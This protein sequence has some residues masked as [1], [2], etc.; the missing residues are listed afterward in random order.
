MAVAQR[1]HTT[2]RP[3]LHHPE[4]NKQQDPPPPRTGSSRDKR[5]PGAPESIIRGCPADSARA[6]PGRPRRGGP[7]DLGIADQTWVLVATPVRTPTMHESLVPQVEHVGCSGAPDAAHRAKPK[8]ETHAQQEWHQ[9]GHHV[10]RGARQQSTQSFQAGVHVVTSLLG[11]RH[12]KKQDNK[13]SALCSCAQPQVD[14]MGCPLC[15]FCTVPPSYP[16]WGSR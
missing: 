15:I 6:G 7:G 9:H 14:H 5:R 11:H 16:G 12:R 13:Q 4:R 2:R 1:E 10:A 3:R 8:A